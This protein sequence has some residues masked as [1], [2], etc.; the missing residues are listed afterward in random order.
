MTKNTARAFPAKRFFVDMLTRDIELQDAILDLLDNCVDGAMRLNKTRSIN[1]MRPYQGFQ[2]WIDF[3]GEKFTITDNCGGIPRDLA[4]TYAFR[5]GRADQNRDPELPTVGVYGIGM[6]R[7]I[8]KM[9]RAASVISQPQDDEGFKVVIDS[10]WL[11]NDDDWDLPIF[12]ARNALDTPGTIIE[13]D[14]LRDGIARLL[15]DET[16]F[17]KDLNKAIAAYY[18]Y[19]I[20]KGFVVTLNGTDVV[21]MQV[22]LLFDQDSFES[23][24]G[25][26]PYAYKLSTQ[27]GVSVQLAVGMYR[28]LPSDADEDD[29]L[30]GRATTERAGWTIICN[31]R[32]VMYADKSRVTGWGEAGVPQYH[33][34]FVSIAG[35]VVFK[36]NDPSKLPITTTKRGIDGNSELYLN[37]KEYMREGLKLFTDFTNKWKHSTPERT[38]M[39]GKATTTNAGSI[40][41]M[42]PKSSWST[43]H[44]GMGGHRYKPSLPTPKETDPIKQIRFSRL[45]SDIQIVAKHLLDDADAAVSDV[46]ARCFDDV[47]RKVRK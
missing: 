27:D 7:A 8:F 19:I 15:S 40:A 16:D 41:E 30:A 37:V 42:V 4:E 32:V 22:A 17:A 47:L 11:D 24:G 21:P 45:R 12:S 34:Q 36:C 31:D 39:K 43:V 20:E 23:G 6:K 14:E 33:T 25:I 38:A 26:V 28:D 2:A 3:D 5:M 1:P 35:V 13:V 46:G 29:A 9:G 10:K 44:K 18:G